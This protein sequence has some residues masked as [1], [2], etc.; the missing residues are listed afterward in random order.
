[1]QERS[2]WIDRDAARPCQ[3]KRRLEEILPLPR[4]VTPVRLLEPGDEPRHRDGPLADTERL[5]AGILEVHDDLLELAKG[6]R[7]GCEEAVEHDRLATGPADEE[8]P[9]AGRPRERSLRDGSD[10]GGRN[11]RVHCIPSVGEHARTRP[12][13]QRVPAGYRATRGAGR[14]NRH[15]PR[16]SAERTFVERASS[17][18]RERFSSTG[19]SSAT[20]RD[21]RPSHERR[22]KRARPRVGA[23]PRGPS[24]RP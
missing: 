4:A 2:R 18:A 6:L 24:R 14:R 15:S 1:M 17:S 16:H 10:E 23:S 21:P 20:R 8:K 22:R 5:G 19:G 13:R 3:S 12:R 9:A 7:R 11:A